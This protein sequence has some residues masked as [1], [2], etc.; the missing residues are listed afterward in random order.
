MCNQKTE[1]FRDCLNE[2]INL[3]LPLKTNDDIN[4][5]VNYITTEI[6]TTAWKCTPTHSTSRCQTRNYP[7]DIKK[8]VLEKRSLRRKWQLSRLPED[9]YAFN[10]AA[11]E[12]RALLNKID[13]D[14]LTHKLESLNPNNSNEYSLWKTVKSIKAPLM[15]KAPIRLD[16]KKW[17]RSDAEKAEVFAQFLKGVFTPNPDNRKSNNSERVKKYLSSDIQMCLPLK[18][19]SPGEIRTAIIKLPLKKAP[20]FDLITSEVL[21]Q[22][23][24]KGIVSNLS[25]QRN[26][27]YIVFS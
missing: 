13:N 12:L 14:N 1:S 5:T 19:I 21:K 11:I 6:Q 22:L 16:D 26:H 7:L 25:I 20:G 10:R 17:A 27:S 15:A 9:K 3:R 23:P 18:S 8:R 2:N 24:K 4:R